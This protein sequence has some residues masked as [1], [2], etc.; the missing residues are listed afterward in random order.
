LTRHADGY[1]PRV[2]LT[3]A[4]KLL[5]DQLAELDEQDRRARG[6]DTQSEQHTLT[7]HPADYGSDLTNEMERN[8][9]VETIGRE[10]QQI[11]D[12][13]QR[14]EEGTYGRCRVD[15]EPIDEERLKARPE[16]DLCLRHQELAERQG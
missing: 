9:M 6:A 3:R 7:Q 12:A 16:A 4:K 11:L 15:G 2:N 1:S 8:L 5:T 10:R 13:L 14:I